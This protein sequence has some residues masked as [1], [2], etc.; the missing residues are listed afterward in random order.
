MSDWEIFRTLRATPV[1]AIVFALAGLEPGPAES[2]LKRYLSDI[3]HRTLS[4]TGADLLAL[5]MKK[6]PA[7][8]RLLERLREM[9]VEGIIKGREAELE[10]AR[11]LLE[12]S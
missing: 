1:E 5:G 2:R 11:R 8:G 12:K 7:V 3:R 6:G 10:Y 4:V 9:R